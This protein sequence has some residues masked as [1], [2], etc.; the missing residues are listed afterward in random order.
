MITKGYFIP[1]SAKAVHILRKAEKELGVEWS[2]DAK[3]CVSIK[4]KA[5]RVSKLEK[6]LSSIV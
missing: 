4:V 3:E 5:N 1:Y 6:M 2:V